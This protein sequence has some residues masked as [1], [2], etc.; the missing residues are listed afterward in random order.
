MTEMVQLVGMRELEQALAALPAEVNRRSIGFKALRAG[1]EVIAEA[2]RALVAFDEGGLRESIGVYT[3]LNRKNFA[4]KGE[5]A[6][7]EVY[8]GPWQSWKG[9]W[10]EFGTAEHTITAE[11]AA[12]INALTGEIFGKNVTIPA[13]PPQPFMRPAW[14]LSKLHALDLI[15]ASLG[16]E[17]EKAAKRVA[18]KV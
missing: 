9:S 7:I 14:D 5:I 15:G 1:G 8:V 18:G 13:I 16:L 2:A 17:V 3:F 4:D 11:G 12:L 10:I 6:P